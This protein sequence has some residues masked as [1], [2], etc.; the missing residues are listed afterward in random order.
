MKYFITIYLL[1]IILVGIFSMSVGKFF[2]YI[3]MAGT[4]G[5]AI[6]MPSYEKGDN[7][8]YY[9]LSNGEVKKNSSK[10]KDLGGNVYITKEDRLIVPRLI[11]GKSILVVPGLGHIVESIIK[12]AWLIFS[13]YIPI[14]IFIFFKVKKYNI[15][16]RK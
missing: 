4:A 13:V 12:Y 16:K 6:H 3:D 10:V 8:I 11:I 7:I 2:G 14:I 1:N 15:N 9:D 5:F